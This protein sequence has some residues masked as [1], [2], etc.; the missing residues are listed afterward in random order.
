MTP[1][2]IGLLHDFAFLYPLLM[3]YVWMAGGT[4]YYFHYERRDRALLGSVPVIRDRGVSIVIPCY[5][6]EDNVRETVHYACQQNY[7]L[8]EVIAVNDGSCDA[9]GAILDELL[10][11]YPQLRVIHL[12]E[13][14]GKAVALTTG[15]QLA[16]YEYLVCI[17]GDAILD[18]NA[19]AWLMRHFEMGARV[20]AVTGN[21]RIRNRST[22]LGRLQVGEFS[23]IIGLIKRAQRT[24]GRI[25]A[26]SGVLAAFRRTAL[27][28]VGYWSHDMLTEDVDISWKL[29]LAHWDVRFEPYALVWILMPETLHGL[30][31]Q[32]LRWAKGGAQ[33]LLKNWTMFRHW[34]KRRMWPIYF[35]YCFS[36]LWAYSMVFIFLLW[37]IGK[38]WL[39]PPE[40][41][42]DSILPG[43][44][45]VVIGTTCLIQLAVSKWLDAPFD[46]HLTRNYYWMIWYPLA[47]WVMG[48][49]TT[50][51]AVPSVLLFERNR[52]ARWTSPDRGLRAPAR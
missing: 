8:F 25:F 26:I 13:N 33:V 31:K 9:T 44:T 51:V 22:L 47:Y 28:E 39:L 14:Q 42:V 48:M 34:R 17:D 3:S 12:Q 18:P 36:V 35:E 21:P 43:W 41:R 32:R 5:N 27:Q 45:G 20:G 38:F 23:S 29:Q 4:Y 19:C 10:E 49:L 40:W 15:A 30:W 7:P 50:A 46:V 52:R 1:E 16:R 6:E 24:Y 2:L 11:R 37:L